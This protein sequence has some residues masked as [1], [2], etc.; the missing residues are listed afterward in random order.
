MSVAGNYQTAATS[1]TQNFA[2][3]LSAGQGNAKS[4]ASAL[5]NS[6]KNSLKGTNIPSNFTQQA[7]TATKV[8]NRPK[9]YDQVDMGQ[10]AL[11]DTAKDEDILK[12]LSEMEIASMTPLEALNT[13][14]RLQSKLKNRW[15]VTGVQG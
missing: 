10:M 7:K 13:L 12:E 1:A 6:A 8:R 11:F 2:R 5:G 4:S 9:T 3:T 15:S 14:N